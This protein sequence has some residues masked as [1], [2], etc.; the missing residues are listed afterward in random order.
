[1]ASGLYRSWTA[2]EASILWTAIRDLP[3]SPRLI[4]WQALGAEIENGEAPE[5]PIT[6]A[7]NDANPGTTRMERAI[8]L[9]D[10]AMTALRRPDA[11]ERL[12]ASFD[13]LRAYR[14]DDLLV[15]LRTP[16]Q[17]GPMPPLPPF[18]LSDTAAPENLASGI[19]VCWHECIQFNIQWAD[20]GRACLVCY[21]PGEWE[22]VLQR[23][24]A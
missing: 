3:P 11:W 21:Q 13:R 2:F 23:L 18:N 14:W 10:L 19:E 15:T 20:D 24:A 8:E 4:Q 7:V 1:M 9:R 5:Q 17:R 12:T 6:S 16:F 22:R